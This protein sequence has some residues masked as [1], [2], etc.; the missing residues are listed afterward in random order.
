MSMAS[1]LVFV[2]GGPRSKPAFK[3][4]LSIGRAYQ[5]YVE[6]MH[7]E[8]PIERVLPAIGEGL[9]SLAVDQILK[10]AEDRAN[11]RLQ[12]AAHLY[13]TYCTE[14]KMIIAQDIQNAQPGQ[15]SAGWNHVR[16]DEGDLAKRGRLFDLIVLPKPT[17]D[18]GG[19]DAMFLEAALFETGRPVLLAS[20]G[21]L[22]FTARTAA[23]AWDGSREASRAA[24]AALPFLKRA[25]RVTVMSVGENGKTADPGLLAASLALHG[26][27]ATGQ[28]VELGTRKTGTAILE[29]A[30]RLGADILV[31]GAYGHG[32]LRELVFGGATRE[33]LKSA[34]IPV[35]LAH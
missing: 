10:E 6:V 8:T 32:A 20:Q 5:A 3:T 34:E 31:M 22:D 33:V 30:G 18:E 24:N 7:V 27:E 21:S 23:I 2:N 12:E 4:A 17:D 35:L 29:E 13:K 1:I 15:F 25:L 26:V 16:G 11:K 14:A 19:V 28:S 9:S